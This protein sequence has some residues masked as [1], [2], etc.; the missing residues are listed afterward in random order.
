MSSTTNTANA[1][2]SPEAEE[3]L[4]K[5]DPENENLLVEDSSNSKEG[6]IREKS[7]PDRLIVAIPPEE[8]EGLSKNQQKKL[9]KKKLFEQNRLVKR[10]KEKERRKE[11][12]KALK[13]AGLELPG[14]LRA[15]HFKDITY[16]NHCLLYTSPS[17]RDGLLSRM[18]SSA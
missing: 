18:P 10:Q 14:R 15:K 9:Y 2:S 6:P 4:K 13:E 3:E 5:S 8:L 11:K 16:C 7:W 12:R 1:P 17:P